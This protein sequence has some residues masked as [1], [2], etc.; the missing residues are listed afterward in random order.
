MSPML[1]MQRRRNRKGRDVS[2]KKVSSTG[3]GAKDDTPETAAEDTAPEA[4]TDPVMAAQAGDAPAAEDAAAPEPA[5][6]N[7]HLEAVEHSPRPEWM[8]VGAAP[9]DS[10][11]DAGDT[12]ESSPEAEQEYSPA[13]ADSVTPPPP[14]PTPAPPAKGGG[15]FFPALLGG[16]IA[17]ALGFG[18]AYYLFDDAS[19]TAG[20]QMEE[21]AQ[22]QSQQSTALEELRTQVEAGPDLSAVDGRFEE[23]TQRVAEVS[24]RIDVMA[25]D[26]AAATDRITE[27]EKR[28]I[29]DTVSEEAIAA[30]EAELDRLRQAMEDQRSEVEA[31]IE[32]A[33]Q[34]ESDANATAEATMRRAA[35]TRILSAL[36]SGTPYASALADLQAAG[37]EVPE[38]LAS[39][40]ESGVPS[41]GDLRASFPD[42]ARR[43]LSAARANDSGG[44]SLGDFLRDNLGARSLEPREGDDADAVLSRA[45][46]ALRN[47]RLGDALAELETL[48][49]P[50]RA[51]M[52]GWIEA[53]ETR[54]AAVAAAET[55]N[56]ELSES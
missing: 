26:M 45:E 27:L 41:L 29:T 11:P 18:I 51:E 6:P 24:D 5:A 34:M 37:Q 32:E 22:R 44:R 10:D 47:A 48:P 39:S 43:A 3:K 7:V 19:R 14:P 56:A 4:G 2:A 20:A 12:P 35:L 15:G 40:A 25:G 23:L 21:L 13:G 16:I 49:D 46:D 17:A 42:A 1:R 30:Y 31:L 54:R 38:A 28:P 52:A 50:A 9:A 55:L 36:D 8:T 33:R 53:A